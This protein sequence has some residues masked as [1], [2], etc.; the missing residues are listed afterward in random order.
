MSFPCSIRIPYVDV[1][2]RVYIGDTRVQQVKHTPAMQTSELAVRS[3]FDECDIEFK[4]RKVDGP[5]SRSSCTER[6]ECDG[7]VRE[8]QV[9]GV[10]SRPESTSSRL[11]IL[12]TG[13]NGPNISSCM[14]GPSSEQSGGGIGG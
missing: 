12:M 8:G 2:V 14:S 4:C 7:H 9:V 3:T 6:G 10:C 5:S 1:D 11:R 13:S